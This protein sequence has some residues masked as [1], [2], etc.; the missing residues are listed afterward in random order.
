MLKTDLFGRE[1]K[2]YGYDFYSGVPCSFLKDLIHYAANECEY[3]MAANEGDAVAVCAGAWLSGRKSVFLCQNSG[4]TNA[5]SPLVSLNHPF[6]IPLMGFVSLRGEEGIGDEPQHELIGKITPGFLD[7]MAIPWDYLSADLNQ[8]REQIRR[9]DQSIKNYQSFFFVVK[10]GTFDDVKLNDPGVRAVANER[11]ILQSR[12]NGLPTRLKVLER[13]VREKDAKTVFL[14]TTG[15]TGRELYEVEDAANHFYMVGSMGCVSSLALGM[16]LTAKDKRMVAIDGD[17]ALLMR[18]GALATIAYYRPA[19]MLHLLLD[20]EIHDSTG[21]QATV[22][23][24]ID[25]VSL[26]AALGYP[27]AVYAHDEEELV[28]LLETWKKNP[29]LTFIYL[30]IAK[31]SKKNLGRPKVKPWE[32]RERLRAYLRGES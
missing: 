19:N 5:A 18:M 32:V 28:S 26:A 12:E 1:L 22:S 3:V 13:L 20:N 15:K 6:R 14:A 24:N 11:K 21:G 31:G 2:A 27:S 7:L 23:S 25:F 4:L 30:K 8:A 10:K 9:A 16:A 29:Q 17:G